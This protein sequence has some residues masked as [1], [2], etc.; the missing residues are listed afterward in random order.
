MRAAQY[1]AKY[2]YIIFSA[3]TLVKKISSTP[4]KKDIKL[5][6]YEI[7][8]RKDVDDGVSKGSAEGNVN[9]F[10]AEGNVEHTSTSVEGSAK[11]Y[12]INVKGSTQIGSEYNNAGIEA[13]GNVLM[14][15]ANGKIGYFD[16]KT[17]KYGIMLGGDAGAY[18]LQGEV[19]PSFTVSGMKV[20]FT[21][22]GS[23]VSAQIG[24]GVGTIYDKKAGKITSM[25]YLK[26][27]LL[28]GIKLGIKT[29]IKTK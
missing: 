9:G 22:G 18:A 6:G 29:E 11:V 23:L 12:G 8:A 3:N 21:I 20:S 19:N 2:S 1:A 26:I 13:Q 27:G 10:G 16:G 25:G 14:A 17:D 24:G 28:G 15:E 5:A 7:Q 4:I